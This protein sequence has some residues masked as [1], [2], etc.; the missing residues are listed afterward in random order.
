[1]RDG[2]HEAEARLPSWGRILLLAAGL[3]GCNSPAPGSE[4]IDT[5]D[6]SAL[7]DPQLPPLGGAPLRAWLAAGSYRQWACEATIMNPRPRGAHGRNRVCSNDLLSAADTSSPFPPGSAAVKELYDSRDRLVGYAVSRKLSAGTDGV[8]WFWSEGG[9]EGIG[10][11]GCAG[12]HG[13]A[14]MYGGHDFVYVRV[15]AAD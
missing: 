1:M 7:D 3:S 8:R 6:A 12:C 4:A 2:R 11:G 10:I 13:Q 14:A 5:T 9:N 15:P